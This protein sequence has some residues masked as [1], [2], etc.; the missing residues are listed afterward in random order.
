MVFSKI[1][2]KI[3]KSKD[4]FFLMLKTPYYRFYNWN[5]KLKVFFEVVLIIGFGDYIM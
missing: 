2:P 4:R 3:Y 5:P 1:R